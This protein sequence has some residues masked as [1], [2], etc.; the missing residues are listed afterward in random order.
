M[1]ISADTEKRMKRGV[2]G[3]KRAKRPKKSMNSGEKVN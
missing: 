3:S 1:T 2:N